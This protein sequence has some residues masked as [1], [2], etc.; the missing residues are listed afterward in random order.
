MNPWS[1][2]GVV[3]AIVAFMF[4]VFVH[5]NSSI[6]KK[7][8]TKFKDPEFIQMVV[9]KVRLPFVIFDENNSIIVDSGAMDHIEKILIKKEDRQEVSEI[10]IS[11]K[12]YLSIAPII[13]NLDANMAF[14]NPIRGH[15]FDL[16]YKR[17]QMADVQWEDSRPLNK[18]P[19]KKFRL[20]I[21]VLPE[22]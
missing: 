1:V 10:I 13:E 22:K 11:P 12:K 15:K 18:R 21:I 3:V 20:Q 7:I 6:D 14:E 5:F 9:D 2:L 17:V 4:A 16:V 19:K 8:E